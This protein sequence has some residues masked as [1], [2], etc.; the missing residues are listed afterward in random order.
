MLTRAL[1]DDGKKIHSG[2]S[3]NDQVL[4]DLRLYFRHRI[5]GIVEQTADAEPNADG[6]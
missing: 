4:V 3:R 5:Q 6:S 1:G 2:R